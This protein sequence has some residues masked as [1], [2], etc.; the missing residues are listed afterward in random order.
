MTQRPLLSIGDFAQ[1]T[2]LPAQ[3][4]RYYHRQGLLEPT[5][6]D[7]ETGY[8]GYTFDQTHRALLIM[9]LRRAAVSISEIRTILA[10]PDLLPEILTEHQTELTRERSQEDNAMAQAWQLATGWP[11][12]DA[13]D[14]PPAAAVIRQVPGET[15]ASDGVML[16]KR[17]RTAAEA[18]RRELVDAGVDVAGPP[19]CQYALQTEEDKEKAKT[20]QGPDWIIAVDL[21]ADGALHPLPGNASVLHLPGRREFSVALPAVPTMA[22][23]AAAVE[24]LTRTLVEQELVPDFSRFRYVLGQDHV[25]LVLAV[26]PGNLA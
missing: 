2:G 14:T 18:L 12:A 1:M 6:I 22:A 23:Y 9:A 20:P 21:P 25:E 10:N 15:A 16:P 4:L 26:D 3:T 19:W 7:E 11:R 17:V 8:R 24:Y 5:Q 13:R